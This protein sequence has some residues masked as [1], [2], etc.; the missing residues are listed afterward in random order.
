MTVIR[1]TETD[2]SSFHDYYNSGKEKVK[3]HH[4]FL[5]FIIIVLVLLFHFRHKLAEAHDRFRTRLRLRYSRFEEE[6]NGFEDD[7]ENGLSSNT[8]D[9]ESNISSGDQREGLLQNAKDEIKR[10]MEERGITFDEAR[11]Q[12]TQYQLGRNNIGKDGTPLDPKTVTFGNH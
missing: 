9:I 7:L 5:V 8:F 1:N 10:I 12:Y 3:S 6:A 11:Y 2:T 4:L